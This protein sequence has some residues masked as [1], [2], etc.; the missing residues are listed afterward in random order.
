MH[1][2]T[3]LGRI[4]LKARTNDPADLPMCFYAL[5]DECN[6]RRED[7]ISPHAL[8]DEMELVVVPPHI[9]A[10]AGDGVLRFLVIVDTRA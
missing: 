6:P 3:D 7:E 10:R 1:D 5:T 9:S 8:P 2:R 4:C